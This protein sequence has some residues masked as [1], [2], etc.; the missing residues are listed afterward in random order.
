MDLIKKKKKIQGNKDRK[1]T[2]NKTNQQQI[3]GSG[4]RL[5]CII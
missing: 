3:E 1:V 2:L 4:E 5:F